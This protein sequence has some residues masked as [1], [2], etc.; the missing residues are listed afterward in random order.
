MLTVKHIHDGIETIYEA[1]H[2]V[3]YIG[4][5]APFGPGGLAI[6][7]SPTAVFEADRD[8]VGLEFTLLNDGT[9]Y[10]MN[11]NGKTVAIYSLPPGPQITAQTG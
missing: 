1:P 8:R 3:E 7:N 5:H 6:K 2:G 9:A 10:V 11:S 4:T